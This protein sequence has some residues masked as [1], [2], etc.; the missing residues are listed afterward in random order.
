MQLRQS[1]RSACVTEPD[2]EMNLAHVFNLAFLALGVALIATSLYNS[3]KMFKAHGVAVLPYSACYVGSS[4]L[5]FLSVWL[6]LRHHTPLGQ[7]AGSNLIIPA[8]VLLS[9]PNAVLWLQK[10]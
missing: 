7:G 8:C 10:H 1:R 5:L 9:L 6:P 2:E 3:T 4:V